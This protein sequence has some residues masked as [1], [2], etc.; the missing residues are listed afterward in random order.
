MVWA[1]RRWSGLPAAERKLLKSK[2]GLERAERAFARRSLPELERVTSALRQWGA[3]DGEIADILDCAFQ[4]RKRR[5]A[6]VV[7]EGRPQSSVRSHAPRRAALAG[8]GLSL[9]VAAALR[10]SSIAETAPNSLSILNQQCLPGGGVAATVAWLGNNP[11][12]GQQRV[13]I[14]LVNNAWLP[15]TFS[16][17]S[18]LSAGTNWMSLTGLAPGVTYQ[19]RVLQQLASGW[20]ETSQTFSYATPAYCRVVI[21]QPTVITVTR[22]TAPARTSETL[23]ARS[24][25]TDTTAGWST[26]VVTPDRRARHGT[27][28]DLGITVR[29]TTTMANGMIDVEIHDPAGARVFQK[30]YDNVVVN[31]SGYRAFAADWVVPA[32]AMVGIYT[33][34]VGVFTQGWGRL[35]HWNNNA[36]TFVVN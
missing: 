12:A 19:L 22:T 28:V 10:S 36:A 7:T 13:D 17:S 14:S 2:V 25:A 34:K 23:G 11:A 16:A 24:S 20:W 1:A 5:L 15:G 6:R 32:N 18:P 35:L 33:V 8:L 26:T 9:V 31:A 21:A 3:S 30:T 4:D 29:R 27:N